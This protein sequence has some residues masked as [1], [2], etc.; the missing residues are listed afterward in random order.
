MF[1]SL[2]DFFRQI[3]SVFSTFNWRDFLDIIFV[4]FVLYS[5]IRIIRETRAIQ[6]LKG[7]L[8]LA[9]IY[10]LTSVLEMNAS[11][12]LI[13]KLFSNI[14]VVL[15]ILF[16]PELR[17]TLEQMGKKGFSKIS[18]FSF[19]NV[20]EQQV[21]EQIEKT[22]DA[23]CRACVSMSDKKVGALIVF[24][25]DVLLGE[26]IKTGTI[27]DAEPSAE[28]IGN[29]FF[30]KAPLHD[31][32]MIVRGGRVYS[33]GCIL[34]LTQNNSI[35]NDLGTRHRAALGIS[36]QSDA[37]VIVVSE[38]TGIISMA[39]KGHLT[40]NLSSGDIRDIL[41]TSLLK[42]KDKEQGENEGN[43]LTSWIRKGLKK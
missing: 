33:A 27:V 20:Q 5:A 37:I 4:A 7:F 25:Q 12:Y 42:T 15:I 19:R 32:A 8:I 41:T 18:P 39:R 34:P 14:V 21:K 31:G 26:I 2:N 11:I 22:I 3:G 29:I 35:S 23:T 40:R 1:E 9:L 24:E 13:H 6:L 16:Q 36:E 30:L 10:A 17:H 28:L 38:E 43:A